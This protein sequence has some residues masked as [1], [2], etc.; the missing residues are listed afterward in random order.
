MAKLFS[1]ADGRSYIVDFTQTELRHYR[2]LAVD[3]YEPKRRAGVVDR[4]IDT[5]LDRVENDLLGILGEAAVGQFIGVKINSDDSLSGDGGVSDLDKNGVTI[6][7][8]TTWYQSGRLLFKDA[9]G[10]KADVAVLVTRVTDS[11]VRIVGFIPMDQ[12]LAICEIGFN[13]RQAAVSC[14]Q[15]ELY[16]M[17]SFM[18]YIERKKSENESRRIEFEERAAIME[19][20]GGLTRAE[21]E[22]AA[23]ADIDTRR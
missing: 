17:R 18:L 22:K 8:K 19:Y 20:D 10:C 13:R 2:K 23:R 11:R 5:S 7:V 14:R 6:Q 15:E 3:R 9:G 21:A 16:P 4:L 1:A 12:F